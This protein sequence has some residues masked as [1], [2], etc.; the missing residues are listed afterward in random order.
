M[1]KT[2]R[3]RAVLVAAAASVMSLAAPNARAQE[4]GDPQAACGGLLQAECLG[5][6]GAGSVAAPGGAAAPDPAD[7][8]AQMKSYRSCLADV[9][10]QC[11]ATVQQNVDINAEAD[12]LEELGRLGGLIQSP[13][14]VVEYYNNAIVYAR[15]GD[16]LS[17]RKMLEKAIAEGGESVDLFQRYAS[18]LKAQEGLI[19]AREIMADIARRNL[20]NKAAAMV[21]ATLAP[22]PSREAALRPLV[23]GEKPFAPAWYEIAALTSADRLG[24]Q[25]L[26]DKRSE[27][28]AL[29]AF[30]EAD[31]KGGVYRWY[32]EKDTVEAIRESARRRSGP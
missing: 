1:P 29:R 13:A 18:L 17:Q 11:P 3:T 19:G 32:L 26:T 25:S 15:R 24:Q 31:E 9:I 5:V 12:A 14:T 4:C 27:R 23:E 21:S 2:V 7:C 20:D 22:A 28:D 8:Q 16:A 30:S 6:L 10:E